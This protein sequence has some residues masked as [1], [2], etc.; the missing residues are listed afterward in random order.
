MLA[1]RS[2]RGLIARSAPTAAEL[3]AIELPGARLFAAAPNQMAL[4]KQL[5]EQTGAPIGDVKSALQAAD[6]DLGKCLMQ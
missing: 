5:R 2:C 4:I 6:W 3:C 1:L